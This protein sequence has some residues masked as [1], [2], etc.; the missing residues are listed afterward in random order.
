VGHRLDPPDDEVE[1]ACADFATGQA[2]SRAGHVVT[3]SGTP[4]A[5]STNRCSDGSPEGDRPVIVESPSRLEHLKLPKVRLPGPHANGL[6]NAVTTVLADPASANDP[7]D[8]LLGVLSAMDL[9]DNPLRRRI[10]I[11]VY[12]D[13]RAAHRHL[14]D[15][16]GFTPGEV[17]VA[18]GGAV[19]HAEVF[20]GDGVIW[21]HPETEEYRLASPATLGRATATM[22]I[23]VDDV[24]DHFR[25]V[26]AKGGDIVYPP[27][28]QPYGYRE[29][30]AR[31]REGTLWSFM[32]ELETS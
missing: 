14:V 24:D 18:P 11:L 21:L 27:T 22:A 4:R 13:L 9:V 17:T 3:M 19:V 6:R 26:Q 30:S 12:R 8:D 1:A 15:V 29:Y 2:Q 7:T 10:S 20:A 28:D 5:R 16:F 23:M 25:V 32:K 31:D